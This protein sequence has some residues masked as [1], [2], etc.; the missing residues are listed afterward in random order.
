MSV[1]Q[2]TFRKAVLMANDPTPS[3]LVDGQGRAAEDRF[4]VYRNNVT[5]ALLDALHKGFPIL[6]KLVGTDRFTSL[7]RAFIQAHPPSDPRMMFYGQAMPEF[8]ETF[9][10]LEH[11]GYLPD[12]ARLEC[13]LR[14]SYHAAEA[15]PITA[16]LLTNL[17]ETQS[18]VFAPSLKLVQSHWPLWDIWHFNTDKNAAKPR[19]I[20]QDVLITRRLFD[21]TPHALSKGGGIWMTHLMSGS[22]L[23]LALD[24]AYDV[25][26]EFDMTHLLM[27][28]VQENALIEIL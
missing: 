3:G 24:A 17:R 2:T 25:E 9:A 10:P 5:V 12:I 15:K 8:L 4:S 14:A 28:L 18:M 7:L 19:E 27:L 23:G 22:P 26:P 11:I 6:H 20:Q 21:P 13:A 16:T 1:T